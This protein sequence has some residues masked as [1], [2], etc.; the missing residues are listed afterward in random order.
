MLGFVPTAR[1][2][3]RAE[4]GPDAGGCA[5]HRLRLADR[6]RAQVPARPA[7]RR[8]PVRIQARARPLCKMAIRARSILWGWAHCY[9]QDSHSVLSRMHMT[10]PE[11]EPRA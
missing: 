8:L 6:D 11:C 3:G 7:R 2:G 5:R 1:A 4:R 10:L 9:L